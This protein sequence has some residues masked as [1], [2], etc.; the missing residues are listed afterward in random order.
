MATLVVI[1]EL[2]YTVFQI[3]NLEV[4]LAISFLYDLVCVMK[5]NLKHAKS[6]IELKTPLMYNVFN[7]YASVLHVHM[8]DGICNIYFCPFLKNIP[9]NKRV[10]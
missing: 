7:S 6:I 5:E 4:I 3:M 8:F 2:L 10:I 9:S 1:Y